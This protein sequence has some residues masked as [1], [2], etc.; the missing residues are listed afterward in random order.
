MVNEAEELQKRCKEVAVHFYGHRFWDKEP[1]GIDDS[2]L[3]EY[4]EKDISED[5]YDKKTG[6][7]SREAW[8][9]LCMNALDVIELVSDDNWSKENS[10]SKLVKDIEKIVDK[11][12]SRE[13]E[14]YLHA[15]S[16][17]E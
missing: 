3:E 2:F 15:K 9:I 14:D 16:F 13:Y 4:I 1:Y 17:G 5:L 12:N 8:K 7:Y 11:I 10:L 6:K